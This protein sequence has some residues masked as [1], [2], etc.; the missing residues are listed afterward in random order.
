[1]GKTTRGAI[2]AVDTKYKDGV[3]L[4]ITDPDLIDCI[5]C[6]D[7]GIST[8]MLPGTGVYV[9]TLEIENHYTPASWMGPEEYD[10]TI[11]IVKFEKVYDLEKGVEING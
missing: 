5:Y 2:I 6:D 3:I 10:M 4:H 9:C 8:K 11:N 7:S 1:M